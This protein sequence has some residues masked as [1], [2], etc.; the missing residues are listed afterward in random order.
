MLGQEVIARRMRW[1]HLPV[2]GVAIPTPGARNHMIDDP[3]NADVWSVS[4]VGFDLAWTNSQKAPG[5][6]C[7]IRVDAAGNVLFREPK[8]A[9]FADAL[10]FI[11]REGSRSNLCLIAL[12]QLTIVPNATGSRPVDKI[13]GSFISW[14]GGGVQ[15]ANRSK[16]GMF[17][18]DAPIWRFKTELGAEEDPERSR[19]AATGLF[20]IEV[21]PALALASLDEGFCMR[22]KGPRYN[23][24]RRKTFKIDDWHRVLGAVVQYAQQAAIGGLADWCID[25]TGIKSPKKSDQDMLDA[26]L[27]ALIGFHWRVRPRCESICLGTPPQAT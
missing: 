11:K 5:A 2:E 6:V 21:F 7:A 22:L 25:H 10:A 23:P 3:P 26:V 17:D 18:D 24:G 8:L 1:F 15:P 14:L 19:I 27:C 4:I 9:S 16:L 20:L 13:A 12:D